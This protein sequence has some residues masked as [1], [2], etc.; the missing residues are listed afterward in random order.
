MV[1]RSALGQVSLSLVWLASVWP[2]LA[3]ASPVAADPSPVVH[4]GASAPMLEWQ[5]AMET[6]DLATLARM[7]DAATIAYPPNTREVRGAA[8][9]M[10]GYADT[11]A[12]DTVKVT[13][14][15]AHW[16]AEGPL[17]VSWGLTTLTFH[18]KAGG[19]DTV[20]HSRFTDAAVK[21]DGGWR[22]LVDH[23]SVAR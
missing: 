18:P 12:T 9:I 4:E 14:D 23:A 21:V 7:H 17:V 5:G 1:G 8:A 22:Y 6:G 20:V 3:A 10:K 13:V 11:F 2:P 15:E 16:V 19:A